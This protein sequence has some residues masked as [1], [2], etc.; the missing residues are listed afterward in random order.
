VPNSLAA[1]SELTDRLRA[2]ALEDQRL[3]ALIA[4]LHRDGIHV[5]VIR[6]LHEWDAATATV[7]SRLTCAVDG[8]DVEG[9]GVAR[10]RVSASVL[11][12]RSA[13]GSWERRGATDG[14]RRNEG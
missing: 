5:S 12:I 6:E 9:L 7:T 2:S 1:P 14:Y 8:C 3:T 10:D 11:A 4:T 13:V